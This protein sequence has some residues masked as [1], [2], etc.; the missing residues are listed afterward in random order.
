[1]VQQCRRIL[2]KASVTS[3][4]KANAEGTRRNREMHDCGYRRFC[5]EYDFIP[6]PIDHWRLVQFSQYLSWQDKRLGTIENYAS[7]LRT[8][9]KLS[10]FQKLDPAQIHYEMLLDSLKRA[11]DRPV[12]RAETMTNELM[13]QLFPYVNFAQELEAVTWTA[14]LVGFNL[15]LRVSNL[16]AVSRNKFDAKKNLVRSDYK[17]KDEFFALGI[18]WSKNLQYKN[19]VNWCPLIPQND[20][21]ICPDRWTRRMVKNIPAEQHEPFFLIREGDERFPLTMGQINRLLKQWSQ[22]AGLESERYTS[23]CLHRGRLNRAHNANLTGETL[24][25][26]GDWASKVYLNYLDIPY[27]QKV[28]VG[29]KIKLSN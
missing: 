4:R 20:W 10:G 8:L 27:K 26:M 17:M 6:Y 21:R 1:M 25:V 23:H 12:R 18:R 14:L 9:Q 29:Q 24:Q 7:S 19:R 5:D 13:I 28:A 16:G 11:D 3:I 2:N 22:K 15:V